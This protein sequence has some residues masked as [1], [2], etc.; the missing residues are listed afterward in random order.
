MVAFLCSDLASYISGC[1]ITVD[2]GLLSDSAVGVR[3]G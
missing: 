3:R 2:G 1:A